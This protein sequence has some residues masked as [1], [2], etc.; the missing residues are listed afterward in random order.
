MSTAFMSSSE[1]LQ[2]NLW[3]LLA[4]AAHGHVQI[5]WLVRD[6]SSPHKVLQSVD[7]VALNEQTGS[8]CCR[9]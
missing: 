8:H 4:V 6:W 5:P 2:P 1:S 3:F 9:G 7:W